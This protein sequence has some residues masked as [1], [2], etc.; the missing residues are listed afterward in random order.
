MTINAYQS[1]QTWLQNTPSSS[2]LKQQQAD[3]LNAMANARKY[4]ETEEQINEKYGSMIEAWNE[5]YAKLQSQFDATLLESSL[6]ENLKKMQDWFPND[7]NPQSS[8][9]KYNIDGSE[10]RID[11]YSSIETYTTDEAFIIYMA[12]QGMLKVDDKTGAII[13]DSTELEK[14]DTNDDGEIS[15]EEYRRIEM[16]NVYTNLAKDEVEAKTGDGSSVIS[17][18]EYLRSKLPS[19]Y[20]DMTD[21]GAFIDNTYCLFYSIDSDKDGNLNQTELEAFYKQMDGW[22]NNE[23]TNKF[24]GYYNVDD[25]D[26]FINIRTEAGKGML[27]QDSDAFAVGDQLCQDLY[28]ELLAE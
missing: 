28:D 10:E 8:Y 4:G 3:I 1:M 15:I 7:T 16:G 27:N 11:E 6:A 20:K 9:S 22:E 2:E 13:Y 12:N 26:S 24:D 17:F 5:N 14:Y 23:Q 21:L 18:E 25:V 19:D